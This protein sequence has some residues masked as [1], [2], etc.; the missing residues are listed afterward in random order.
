MFYRPAHRGEL[1]AYAAWATTELSYSAQCSYE[2]TLRLHCFK[3]S[4]EN[5][6]IILGIGLTE[7]F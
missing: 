2:T 1:R 4:S 6:H 7:N 5:L 3:M